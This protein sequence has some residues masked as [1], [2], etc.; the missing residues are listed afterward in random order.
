MVIPLWNT[1]PVLQLVTRQ[2]RSERDSLVLL[3]G[4]AV[5]QALFLMLFSSFYVMCV[6]NL[7]IDAYIVHSIKH[8]CEIIAY[9]HVKER[10]TIA[11]PGYSE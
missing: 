1:N 10:N 3:Y 8:S 7:N 6:W 4:F 11:R 9:Y 2:N 5:G